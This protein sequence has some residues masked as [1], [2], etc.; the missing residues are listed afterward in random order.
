MAAVL[1]IDLINMLEESQIFPDSKTEEGLNTAANVF[2]FPLTQ[3]QE[4]IEDI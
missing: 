1:S 4:V 2:W 3:L